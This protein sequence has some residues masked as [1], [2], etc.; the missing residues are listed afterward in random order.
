MK[1]KKKIIITIAGATITLAL[2][3]VVA[4]TIVNI[5][6]EKTFI[7]ENAKIIKNKYE[8]L[9][10]N[11]N[12]YNQIRTDFSSKI[13]EFYY[14]NFKEEKTEYDNLLNEYNTVIKKINQTI[15]VIDEKCNEATY[16]ET[17][18]AKTCSKYKDLYNKVTDIYN[19]DIDKYN[20]N[21][22]GYND[23]KNENIE[24]FKKEE[25]LNIK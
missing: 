22:K 11:I 9:E 18:V 8:E 7:E 16:K 20:D 14:D 24:L 17:E 12:K 15:K 4:I 25:I 1:N 10:T 6:K 21:L 5:K 19:T 2:V 13:S 3:S 23:Y